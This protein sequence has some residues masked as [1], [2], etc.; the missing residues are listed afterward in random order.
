MLKRHLD[1]CRAQNES[2]LSVTVSGLVVIKHLLGIKRCN[3]TLPSTINSVE[4]VL[5]ERLNRWN[6]RAKTQDDGT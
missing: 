1:L 5:K 3:F 4:L 6:C 2:G